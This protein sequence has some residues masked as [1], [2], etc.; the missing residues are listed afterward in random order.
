MVTKK[1]GALTRRRL[2]LRRKKKAARS[3]KAARAKLQADERTLADIDGQIKGWRKQEQAGAAVMKRAATRLRKLKRPRA[4]AHAAVKAAKAA[5][6]AAE[7][8]AV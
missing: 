6:K 5:L 1:P 4:Q 7:R 3:V 2:R 8:S